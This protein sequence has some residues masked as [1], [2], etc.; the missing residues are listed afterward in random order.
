MSSTVK[1]TVDEF[2]RY[3]VNKRDYYDAMVSNG[4]YLP[5]Y[6]SSII[7]EEYMQDVF[8]G[9]IFCP[10]FA[11]I[12][13]LP[14]PRPPNKDVLIKK[15]L[16][17][18]VNHNFTHHG[19]DQSHEP[20][21]RWLIDLISSFKPEDEIF[22]KNY[23]PPAHAAKLSEMKTIEMPKD[24]MEGL[25]VTKR[26]SRRRGLRVAKD[27]LAKQKKER[28]RF[29]EKK[30]GLQK[31]EEE[32]KEDQRKNQS[33]RRG[34]HTTTNEGTFKAGTVTPQKSQR[35]SAGGNN[36]SSANSSKQIS[37]NPTMQ[38]QN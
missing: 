27:G 4:Y 12:K 32:A 21:K 38:P 26:R 28:F 13:M 22:K 34:V 10:R 15:V 20:D 18:G 6:K 3:I 31:L 8:K 25:P 11:D 9:K 24:F 16:G 2:S 5:K 1:M 33:R 19:M 14:C 23:R 36:M 35:Q 37:A 30:Y 29:M 7:T 17:I